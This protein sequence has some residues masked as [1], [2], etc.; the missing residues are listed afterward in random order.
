MKLEMVEVKI[1]DGSKFHRPIFL[2]VEIN[3]LLKLHDLSL[4]IVDKVWMYKM[5]NLIPFLSRVD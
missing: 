4:V 1:F 2:Y 3:S 5:V